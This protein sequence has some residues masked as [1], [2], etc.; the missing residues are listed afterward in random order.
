[1]KR[2]GMPFL[3]LDHQRVP[4]EFGYRLVSLKELLG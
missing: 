1:M 3:A 4:V 2:V